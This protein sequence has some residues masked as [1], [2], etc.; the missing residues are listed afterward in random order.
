MNFVNAS[1]GNGSSKGRLQV[2]ISNEEFSMKKKQS[3]GAGMKL[4]LETLMTARD[5]VRMHHW[6]MISSRLM[7]RQLSK[8]HLK[9]ILL[10]LKKTTFDRH[11]NGPISIC[12]GISTFHIKMASLTRIAQL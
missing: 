1:K 10:A 7:S 11:G 9:D 4:V 3:N 6:T 12:R 5:D 2:L 8:T